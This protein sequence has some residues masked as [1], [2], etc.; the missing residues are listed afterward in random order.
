MN[1]PMLII[2]NIPAKKSNKNLTGISIALIILLSNACCFTAQALTAP[3]PG[4]E[5]MFSA[6]KGTRSKLV[7][8]SFH[9]TVKKENIK[10]ASGDSANFKFELLKATTGGD[11]K[12]SLVFEPPVSFV[13][14]SRA[15]LYVKNDA[16]TI[17]KLNLTGLSTNALEGENEPPLS[18]VVEV[19]GYQVNVGWKSLANHCRPELQGDEIPYS[20]FR[21]AGKGKVQMTPVARYSPDFELPFGYYINTANGPEKKESGILAKAGKYPE[22]QS[23]FPQLALGDGSFDPGNN[24]FGFYATGPTHSAYSEDVWNMLLHPEHAVRAVRIYPVHDRSGNNLKNTYLICFEEAKNGD[25]NDYVFLVQNVTPVTTSSFATIF[26]GKNLDGWHT[27]IQGKGV[28]TDP[29][30]NFRIE[31]GALHV[32]GKDLGYAIT[33]I[34]YHN[35]HFK[36]EFK[37]GQKKWPPREN[38]KRDAG[39]CYNIPVNEPDSIWPV[40]IECQVQEGDVGDFWLLGFSTINVA[41]KINIPSS[42]TQVVK[43]RDGEKPNGEWNTVEVISYNGHCIHIVNGVVVNYGKEASVQDG[44]ILL[45][46]EYSEVWYRNLKLRKL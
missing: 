42:H 2:K 24:N 43:N 13:G 9:T 44:R 36:T 25:Y 28:N 26:N 38:A 39:I 22:H 40:S 34:P 10:W 12:V 8:A 46:S 37:W 31:E 30:N 33:E 20:L 18:A 1:T 6:I 19:L 7:T 14:I 27:F 5:Y 11:E 35:Y 3:N 16:G 45:Q 4:V 32:I 41:G 21:K 23:L 17:V 29:E 15:S